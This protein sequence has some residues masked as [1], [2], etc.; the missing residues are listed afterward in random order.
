MIVVFSVVTDCFRVVVTDCLMM[1]ILSPPLSS[2]SEVLLKK[3]DN[4]QKI[5]RKIS[6][7]S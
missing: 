7:F 3:S 2:Q 1:V 4:N 6:V 5:K